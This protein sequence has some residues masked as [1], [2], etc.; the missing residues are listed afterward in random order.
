[1]CNLTTNEYNM[2]DKKKVML[3]ITVLIER[4]GD[5]YF[6]YS[7]TMPGLFVEGRTEEEVKKNVEEAFIGYLLSLMKHDEPLPV[8][9]VMAQPERAH[10]YTFT[11]PLPAYA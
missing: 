9:S 6:A 1:M 11:Q 5:A 3:S 8:G 2:L 10:P 4:D 7:P